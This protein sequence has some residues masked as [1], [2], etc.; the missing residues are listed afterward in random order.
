MLLLHTNDG[1]AA[2]GEYSILS[3]ASMAIIQ[4]LNPEKS[5]LGCAC[6]PALPRLGPGLCSLY[7]STASPGQALDRLL[8]CLHYPVCPACCACSGCD[9]C[10]SWGEQTIVLVQFPGMQC[11]VG[12][13]KMQQMATMVEK[14]EREG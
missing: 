2:M 10:A 9:D 14:S 5:P 6:L 12:V 8:V 4:A 1:P 11:A 7:H 13:R 3:S